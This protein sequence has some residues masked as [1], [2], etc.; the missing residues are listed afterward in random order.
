[1][2]K[3][4]VKT[5][6]SLMSLPTSPGFKIEQDMTIPRSVSQFKKRF[7]F[8]PL[9]LRPTK[10]KHFWKIINIMKYDGEL[11]P[12]PKL[13][14]WV[15]DW[16]CAI[17]ARPENFARMRR[18]PLR[19][20][21]TPKMSQEEVEKQIEEE[22]EK[23]SLDPVPSYKQYKLSEESWLE[24]CDQDH[25]GQE[26]EQEVRERILD[27]PQ[28]VGDTMIWPLNP[29]EQQLNSPIRENLINYLE[30]RGELFV[31]MVNEAAGGGVVTHRVLYRVVKCWQEPLVRREVR[32]ERERLPVVE[33]EEEETLAGPMELALALA[34]APR[35]QDPDLD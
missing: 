27:I 26:E 6:P 33:E 22:E 32:E 1:M 25:L 15:W 13:H 17:H 19:T 2:K 9:D 29:T 7:N 4:P 20:S 16:W 18:L 8:N 35:L 31:S 23:K 24:L 3:T 10:A 21:P 34:L 30:E 12:C 28:I 11:C 5:P 14:S